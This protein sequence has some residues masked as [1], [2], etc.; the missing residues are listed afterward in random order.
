MIER[1]AEGQDVLEPATEAPKPTR[2]PDLMAALE[3]SLAAVKGEPLAAGARRRRAQADGPRPPRTARAPP[4]RRPPPSPS[5]HREAGQRP[6]SRGRRPPAR[7]DQPRQGP[8]A[9]GP[10]SPRARRSTT[11]RG[12]PRRSSP[13]CAAARSLGCASP[14][15]SPTSPSTRSAPRRTRPDWVKTAPL[16]FGKEGSST[17]S[18][19]TTGR[20]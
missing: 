11:T 16:E 13:T 1:K 8:L 4:S 10:G 2:A 6:R 12:S 17:S 19:A 18:S 15:A 20:R 5:R 7:P 3:E 14:T 9:R